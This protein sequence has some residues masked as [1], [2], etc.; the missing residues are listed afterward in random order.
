MWSIGGRWSR[1]WKS[2]HR[3]NT[4]IHE[5]NNHSES[6]TNPTFMFVGLCEE[7]GVEKPTHALEEYAN[8]ANL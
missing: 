1:T 7:S 4:G 2:Q 6:Q 5:T 8:P 3:V